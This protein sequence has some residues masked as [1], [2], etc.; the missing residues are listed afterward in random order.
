MGKITSSLIAAAAVL[1]SFTTS[2]KAAESNRGFYEGSYSNTGKMVFFASGNKVIS[3]YAFDSGSQ[4]VLFGSGDL[5]EDGT[6][7]LT[8]TGSI[9]INGKLSSGSVTATFQSFS[10]TANRIQSFGQFASIAGR[11]NGI[12]HSKLRD[13]RDVRFLFDSDGHVFFVGRDGDQTIGGEGSMSSTQERKRHHDGDRTDSD[14]MDRDGGDKD[15]DRDEHEDDSTKFFSGT[16]TITLTNGQTIT[17]TLDFS[18]GKVIASFNLNGVDFDFRGDREATFNRLANIA[19]RGFVNN[20]QG[21]LIGGFIVT[22]GSKMVMIRALGQ[23][24][25]ASGVSPVLANPKVQLFE[26]VSGQQKMVRENDDWE[27]NSNVDEM[28]KTGIAPKD[29]KEAALLVRLEPGA[30]TTVLS[31]SDG[32][33][34]IALVEVYEIDRD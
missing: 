23:S 22:G 30:Y 24:L 8:L 18:R 12:A 11:F 9:T 1:L 21:Q 13:L 3:A 14:D 4:K 26:T 2:A 29:S 33:T 34:G 28:K 15:A 10:I 20:G 27:Q 5:K 7:T 31:G 16:F 25:T 32:G 6:F 19:T 17:G